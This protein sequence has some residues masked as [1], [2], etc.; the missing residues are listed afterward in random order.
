MR[1]GEPGEGGGVE[2][3][4]HFEETEVHAVDCGDLD[5]VLHPL[6][7]LLECLVLVECV[8]SDQEYLYDFTEEHQV[9][10]GYLFS[11]G[12]EWSG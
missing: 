1:L 8:L 6:T 5:H 9:S 10:N 3:L 12:Y 2:L 7:G 4:H 11:A